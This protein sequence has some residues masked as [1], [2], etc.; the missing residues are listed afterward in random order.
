M[1]RLR[2]AFL[3]AATGVAIA[4]AVF[5]AAIARSTSSTAGIGF[6]FLPFWSAPFAVPFFIFGYCVPD[7]VN[8]IK[9][10][11]A[12]VSGW[13]LVRAIVPI[14]LAIWG[15]SYVTWGIVFTTTVNAVRTMSEPELKTFLKES[16]LRNNKFALGALA[17]NPNASPALLDQV[18]RIPD[19]KLHERMGSIWPVMGS[20]GHG[21]A[22]MRLIARHPNVSESTLVCLSKSTDHYVLSDIVANSKTPTP[23]LRE[24]AQNGDYLINWGLAYNSKT[25]SEILNKI[26]DTGDEYARSSVAL[27]SGTPVKTLVQLAKDPI[28]HVRRDVV[29]NPHTPSETIT[30]LRN[31][32]DERV[33]NLVNYKIGIRK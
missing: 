23:I 25:P 22:V 6:L 1:T 26:A 17:E 13:M 21:L 4:G 31:D 29:S 7:L 9:R 28:W 19:H 24:I 2:I 5:F 20:N 8:W 12:E 3:C 32:P 11:P 30:S 10:K 14:L 18:A 15:I 27:N 33:R 16:K